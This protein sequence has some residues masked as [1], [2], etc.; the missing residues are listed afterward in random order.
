LLD[1]L[2]SKIRLHAYFGSI[3]YESFHPTINGADLEVLTKIIEDGKIKPLVDNVYDLK[4]QHI[5][6]FEYLTSRKSVGKNVFK[7]KS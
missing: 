2:S 7:I 5:E 3:N 6:A 1:I 4:T